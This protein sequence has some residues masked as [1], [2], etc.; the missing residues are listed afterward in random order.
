MEHLSDKNFTLERY[1]LYV[2]FVEENDA[3]FILELRTNPNLNKYINPTRPDIEAQRQWVR[4]YKERQKKKEDFYFMF[5][6]PQ[7]IRLGVCRIYDITDVN[8]TVGS[9]VFSPYAPVGSAILADIITRE[10]AYEMFPD[11]R[12]LF[13]VK[14]ANTTVNRYHETFKSELLFQDELTNYY[15]CSR[16]NFEKYKK[17]HLRMFTQKNKLS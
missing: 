17:I 9:W 1:G 11:K 2:R 6:Q 10:I 13:D 16:E 7:G 5:E 15:M 8:F 14:R 4:D 3:E 12:H